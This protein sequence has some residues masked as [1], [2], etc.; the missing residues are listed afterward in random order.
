MVYPRRAIRALLLALV[1][2]YLPSTSALACKR[3]ILS[4]DFPVEVLKHYNS[5][6]VVHVQKVGIRG[7]KGPVDALHT[8]IFQAEIVRT[9]RGSQ[10]PGAIIK[11]E[12]GPPAES[13]A[14][15]LT[16]LQDDVDYLVLLNRKGDTYLIDRYD[17]LAVPSDNEYFEKY[18]A[19]IARYYA[20]RRKAERA[21]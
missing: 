13:G 18:V 3:A 7:F 2:C 9:L 8:F 11:G 1:L 19:R 16:G 4:D 14:V 12:A 6:Y 17:A 10:Q 15:C 5:I 21:P 20:T